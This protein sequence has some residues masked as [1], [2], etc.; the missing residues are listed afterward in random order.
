MKFWM[1]YLWK[2][3]MSEI[4]IDGLEFIF[5][6]DSLVAL[7]SHPLLITNNSPHAAFLLALLVGGLKISNERFSVIQSRNY[8]VIGAPPASAFFNQN[9]E[10]SF[11]D[12]REE[13]QGKFFF[14]K[15][16]RLISDYINSQRPNHA[17]FSPLLNE[18][19]RAIIN[20]KNDRG[21]SAFVHIYRAV[22]SSSYSFP[23]FYCRYEREYIKVFSQL[24]E[25][26]KGGELDFCNNFFQHLLGKDGLKGIPMRINFSGPY[27]VE[28][29]DCM[30]SISW[31]VDKKN[32]ISSISSISPTAV[33]IKFEHCFDL[34]IRIRNVFFHQLSGSNSSISS[35][36][37]KDADKFFEPINE[38]GLQVLAYMYGR[39]IRAHI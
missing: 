32:N 4:C 1:K 29:A 3:E 26:F 28:L 37:V 16:K 19:S 9:L 12:L 22:E 7:P 36:K 33:E 34:I 14:A 31:I 27:A 35:S 18:I 2:Y 39:I 24:K 5:R 20:N 15:A 21:L 8:M 6:H 10:R 38:V 11:L 23:L 13:V 25:F 30:T 17:L